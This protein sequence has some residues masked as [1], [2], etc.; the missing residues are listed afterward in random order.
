[1]PVGIESINAYG[2]VAYLDIRTLFKA[3]D[4]DLSRFDNL[5]MEKKSV[6]LPCE[7]PVSNG[8]NAAKPIIE[9]LT[10][11]EINNIE[12]LIAATESA[13]D[14]GKALS[15]YLHDYL[16]LTRQCRL[17]EIKQACYA[18][19]A[20]LQMAINTITASANPHAKALVIATDTTRAVARH[21]YGEPSQGVAAVAML[22]SR[23]PEILAVDPG[24][25]GLYGYEV[26]DTCRPKP[27]LEVGDN[28]LSLLSYLDCFENSYTNYAKKVDNVDF[29][30]TFDYLVFHTPFPGMVKG[31]H[32]KLMRQLK[33]YPPEKIE[34]DF[35]RRVMPSF[36][37][38]V[39][40]GN[41]YSATTYL[42][43]CGLVDTVEIDT[44]KR[45]GIFSYG[46]GCS[47]EFYS[48]TVTPQAKSKLARMEIAKQLK[49]RYPLAMEEYDR[50]ADL[51]EEW[52]FGIENKTMDMSPFH[53]IYDRCM[54]GKK[55]L[56]LKAI[57]GYHREYE[58]S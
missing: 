16:G 2:G 3:R 30:T 34:I 44:V 43:L 32:R 9:A 12:L 26:M 45:V 15:T 39:E 10:P 19:T 55:L 20:A 58:W 17:F 38:C 42:A 23:N 31:A 6:S 29:E 48:G 27:E 21:T 18:G 7:D 49:Q 36:K 51:N 5:M 8:V 52:M 35:R 24:A 25:Y 40:V 37:Y 33:K 4:L 1:M 50:I 13:V 47:S 57:K 11:Q 41:V 53:S 28:D 56:Y 46:S 22:I 14:F 54:A